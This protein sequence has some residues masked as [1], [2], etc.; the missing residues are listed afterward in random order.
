MIPLIPLKSNTL[1][2]KSP[3]KEPRTDNQTTRQ[4]NPTQKITSLYTSADPFKNLYRLEWRAHTTAEDSPAL[5]QHKPALPTPPAV[6]EANPKL[7]GTKEELTYLNGQFQNITLQR[8]LALRQVQRAIQSAPNVSV[9]GAD[10][11][12]FS[13]DDLKCL[14]MEELQSLQKRKRA[15][16][17]EI[18]PLSVVKA[19]IQTERS[20]RRLEPRDYQIELYERARA[21]NTI[22]VLGTG[23]GKTL[24]ACLLIK[25]IL[26]QEKVRRINGMKVQPL[27]FFRVMNRRRFV[28]LWCRWYISYFNR[29][30]SLKLILLRIRNECALKFMVIRRPM[31]S[32]RDF[33]TRKMSLL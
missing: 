2:N 9:V 29:E 27:E 5:F 6:A 1:M 28:F 15:I 19:S 3:S 31:N 22:A 17:K 32:G 16:H 26:V 30:M 8:V 11:T 20:K 14:T 25:D 10:S 21:E 13:E 12:S 33:S 18:Q 7:N 4:Y 24:I 23:T